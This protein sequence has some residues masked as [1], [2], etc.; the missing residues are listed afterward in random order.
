[1][2]KMTLQ[3]PSGLK[4]CLILGHNPL[5]KQKKGVEEEEG[6]AFDAK[7]VERG[8][9]WAPYAIAKGVAG[10]SPVLP[11]DTSLVFVLIARRARARQP[12]GRRAR[13]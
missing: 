8:R 6:L 1:M 12:S 10:P 13:T 4:R 5:E 11:P 3:A 7:G 2:T 9:I